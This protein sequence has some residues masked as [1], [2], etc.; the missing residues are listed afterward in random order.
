MMGSDENGYGKRKRNKDVKYHVRNRIPASLDLKVRQ[1]GKIRGGEGMHALNPPFKVVIQVRHY[2]HDI[3]QV[4][5]LH[6]VVLSVS[7]SET[8]TKSGLMTRFDFFAQIP[9]LWNH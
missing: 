2:M 4:M 5:V 9:F 1:V 3:E 8:T 6:D 7:S